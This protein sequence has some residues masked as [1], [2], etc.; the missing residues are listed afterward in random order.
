MAALNTA[1]AAAETTATKTETQPTPQPPTQP[2]GPRTLA[3]LFSL[4]QT[5]TNNR[6]M[7]NLNF[8]DV[9]YTLILLNGLP[10]KALPDSGAAI[11]VIS[12]RLAMYLNTECGVT[13]ENWTQ[14]PLQTADGRE[15]KPTGCI[16]LVRIIMGTQAIQLPV[17]VIPGLLPHV[18]L[19]NDF[20]RSMSIII[21]TRNGRVDHAVDV[22]TAEAYQE[23][24]EL[25]GPV[26]YQPTTADEE[27]TLYFR[28][29]KTNKI[30]FSPNSWRM[31]TTNEPDSTTECEA[32]SEGEPNSST[33]ARPP[34]MALST[35][36][37]KTT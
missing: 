3:S 33:Q 24:L 31:S 32:S 26:P 16:P 9:P 11:T 22:F 30:L 36:N 7:G 37:Q 15:V 20:N 27:E 23:M 28:Y 2:G 29:A 13:I 1:P 12:Y 14:G 19:G 21:S 34:L 17:A 4:K 18:I 35:E 10:L 8:N 5:K 25:S 6:V